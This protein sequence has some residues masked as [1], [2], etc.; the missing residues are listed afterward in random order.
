MVPPATRIELADEEQR[1]DRRERD[2]QLP[3][4]AARVLGVEVEH[5]PVAVPLERAV[6]M[7]PQHLAVEEPDGDLADPDVVRVL[8]LLRA[9]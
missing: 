4:R 1:L 2:A 6:Q 7:A 8:E 9:A 5:H 3:D